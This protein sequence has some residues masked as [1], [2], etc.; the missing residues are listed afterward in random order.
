MLT[1]WTV[2]TLP[3]RVPPVV[4][5]SP[6]LVSGLRL[7][8]HTEVYARTGEI[9]MYS[10]PVFSFPMR[11]CVHEMEP[12]RANMCIVVHSHLIAVSSVLVAPRLFIPWD[13]EVRYVPSLRRWL[14][15]FLS[16]D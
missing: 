1:D 2:F 15:S 10:L 11:S 3:P 16:R 5:S 6:S 4:A 9:G 12:G 14:W 13:M 7:D 8:N